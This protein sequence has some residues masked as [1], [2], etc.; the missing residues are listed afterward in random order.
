MREALMV[1][2][3][4]GDRVGGDG[5][6]FPEYVA[7]RCEE[8]RSRTFYCVL[9]RVT[10]ANRYNMV[11]HVNLSRETAHMVVRRCAVHDRWEPAFIEQADLFSGRVQ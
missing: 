5:D 1:A 4:V 10:I 8:I 2:A 3:V 6:L 7:A 9:C 11:Q